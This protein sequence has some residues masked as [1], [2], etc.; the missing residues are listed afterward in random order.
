MD[1]TIPAPTKASTPETVERWQLGGLIWQ[2][3]QTVWLRTLIDSLRMELAQGRRADALRTAHRLLEMEKDFTDAHLWIGRISQDPAEKRH[4]LEL[5]LALLPG[6]AEITRELMVLN[7]QLTRAEATRA[8]DLYDPQQRTADGVVKSETQA[9]LCPICRGALTVNDVTGVTCKF[10]GYN[11]ADSHNAIKPTPET[12]MVVALIQQRSKATQWQVGKRMIHCNECG[13][14]RVMPE[15][16]M[17][18]RC[19]F[20][21]SVQVITQDVLGAFR[22]PDG[23]LRFGVR[24]AEAET[25]IQ[26]A[27]NSRMEKMKGWF[28]KNRVV[29]SS[30]Q[31]V[32]L[33]FWEFDIFGKVLLRDDYR[34]SSGHADTFER[35]EQIEQMQNALVSAVKSPPKALTDR[36]GAWQFTEMMPYTPQLLAKFPAELYRIDFDRA[37]LLVRDVFREAM[38]AKHRNLNPNVRRTIATQI[39]HMELRLLLMPVWIVTL[40]EEDGELRTALINGQTGQVVMGSAHKPGA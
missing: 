31:G 10:C 27:L 3:E 38:L 37:G 40:T 4:H 28:I 9:L 13:A 21:G 20:C 33:P 39:D 24:R 14:E 23:I 35:S 1:G 30:Y 12:T 15:G 18:A 34:D 19:P 16:K 2:G 36:L 8:G 22:Q 26:T 17:S 32:Y 11:D 5:A 25:I 6:N 7:G 29:D